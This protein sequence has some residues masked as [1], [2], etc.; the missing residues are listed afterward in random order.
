MLLENRDDKYGLV[1]F[2]DDSVKLGFPR[3]VGFDGIQ[4]F[5]DM[6]LPE[7][8]RKR[9][10][11]LYSLDVAHI[12]K[13][14]ENDNKPK[15]WT[16]PLSVA[17]PRAPDMTIYC[18][19]GHTKDTE[20]GYV[21]KSVTNDR[22]QTLFRNSSISSAEEEDIE[23]PILIDPTANDVEHS[24]SHG[25]IH[26][27]GDGTVPLLSLGFVCR[28]GWKKLNHLN[29]SQSKIITREYEHEPSSN[30]VELRGG[31]KTGDHV[32]ILGNHEFTLDILKIVSNYRFKET[33]GLGH[34]PGDRILSNIDALSE[35]ANERLQHYYSSG[36]VVD[37]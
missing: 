18:F 24:M 12:S 9:V 4:L 16:N 22:F 26:G 37:K 17:L 34:L 7:A 21:Y 5:I 36:M 25:V 30:P 28:F 14:N 27:D 33:A 3:N 1:T 13:I 31:P 11:D 29:P 19:Y 32:D 8:I 15:E 20:L 6:F 23:I 35:S 2:S 10:T